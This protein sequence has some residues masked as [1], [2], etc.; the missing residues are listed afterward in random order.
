MLYWGAGGLP[1]TLP[2]AVRGMVGGG[3]GHAAASSGKGERVWSHAWA[4]A[5]LGSAQTG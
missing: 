5:P 2:A 1:R 3:G 4:S